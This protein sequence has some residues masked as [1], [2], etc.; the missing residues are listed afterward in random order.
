M[1]KVNDLIQHVIDDIRKI[2]P[3]YESFHASSQVTAK[4]LLWGADIKNRRKNEIVE[5]VNHAAIVA[6]THDIA[7]CLLSKLFHH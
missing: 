4:E 2:K 6:I 5:H 7:E 1:R 3:V